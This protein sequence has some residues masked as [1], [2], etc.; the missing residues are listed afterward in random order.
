MHVPREEVN[1]WVRTPVISQTC[2]VGVVALFLSQ[3]LVAFLL[4]LQMLEHQ[5]TFRVHGLCLTTEAT[6]HD[7]LTNT[8]TN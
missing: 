5:G 1:F 6:K 4:S 2:S 7:A 3:D 8:L